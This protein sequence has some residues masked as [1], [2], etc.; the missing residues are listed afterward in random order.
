VAG[1]GVLAVVTAISAAI[2]GPLTSSGPRTPLPPD[3]FGDVPSAPA[4][5][6]ATPSEPPGPSAG[7]PTAP[8]FGPGDVPAFDVGDPIPVFDA[9]GTQAG[10]VIVAAVD[11]RPTT[12]GGLILAIE[13]QYDATGPIA[14]SAGTWAAR[15]SAGE[16]VVGV[17][18]IDPAAHPALPRSVAAGTKESGWLEFQLAGTR[19]SVWV[20][21]EIGGVPVFAVV[22]Y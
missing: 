13:F 22:L 6:S 18:P 5:A 8:G 16:H 12:D 1:L 4:R 19:D 21:S 17:E 7:V 2:L 20:G 9:T 14:I 15:T 3:R 11:P 10:T